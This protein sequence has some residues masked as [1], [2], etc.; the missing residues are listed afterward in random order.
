MDTN[1]ETQPTNGTAGKEYGPSHTKELGDLIRDARFGPALLAYW[2]ANRQAIK[3]RTLADCVFN[4]A[5]IQADAKNE[6]AR[7]AQ[8][9]QLASSAMLEASLLEADATALR[10]L[11]IH[12]RGDEGRADLE[13]R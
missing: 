10:H 5:L 11:V 7:K 3:A 2:S 6:A 12:L 4:S 13:D 9:E 8:A 1:Q